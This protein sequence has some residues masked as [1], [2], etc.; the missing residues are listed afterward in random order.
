M[1]R[2]SRRF[3]I[4]AAMHWLPHGISPAK[5]YGFALVVLS[6]AL[7]AA[8]IV[9]EYIPDRIFITLFPAIA[10][11]S[12]LCG[13]G[14]SILVSVLGAAAAIYF[15]MPPIPG[16]PPLGPAILNALVF[17]GMAGIIVILGHL[18]RLLA[19]ELRKAHALAELRAGEMHHRIQNLINV[20]MALGRGSLPKEEGPVR[21]FWGSFE[22]RLRGLS[23]AQLLTMHPEES[24]DLETL[25]W[26]VLEGH[27]HDRFQIG[28][29]ACLIQT[30]VQLVLVLHE[31]ATN[32]LKY[33][34]LS[35]P[36]GRVEIRWK[37]EGESVMLHWE[38]RGVPIATPPTSEGF[39][40]RVLRALSATRTFHAD[41][42]R[43]VFSIPRA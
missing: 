34:G 16:W 36:A 19:D 27:D 6:I 22:G 41:G 25:I 42:V 24:V 43:V 9:L 23:N 12:L 28:G 10:V 33:G 15:W 32:A 37:P 35:T 29:P 38:E 8:D 4:R 14:P 18:V 39:G 1:T 3:L 5:R 11:V 17:L 40:S 26:R 31:L 30:S 13:V 20:A 7:L 2:P 21:N